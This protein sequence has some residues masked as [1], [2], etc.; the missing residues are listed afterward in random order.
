MTED[1]VLVT[2][3]AFFGG[4]SSVLLAAGWSWLHL[5]RKRISREHQIKLSREQ[6]G[7]HPA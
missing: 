6:S 7:L 3:V 4:I 1:Q 2:I 5:E